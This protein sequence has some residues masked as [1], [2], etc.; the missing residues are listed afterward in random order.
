MN[1]RTSHT[2]E[3]RLTSII[4]AFI[5][6]TR[7]STVHLLAFDDKEDAPLSLKLEKSQL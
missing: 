7:W 6:E 2:S 4:Q 5:W 3:E 1:V